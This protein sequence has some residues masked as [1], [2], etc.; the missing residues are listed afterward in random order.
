MK[1]TALKTFECP[2]MKSTYT[3]G[4]SYT[5]RAGNDKL[6]EKVKCWLKDGKVM[7]GGVEAQITGEG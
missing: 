5:I 7:L 1:F 2:D 4:M 6:A 3:A